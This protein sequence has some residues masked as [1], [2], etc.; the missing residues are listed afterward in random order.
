MTCGYQNSAGT[1]LD[2]LFYIS[3]GNAGPV[4]FQSSNGQDLGNRYSNLVLLGI[5]LAIKIRLGR[6]WAI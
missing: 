2:S 4:G 3:N 6:T 5:P 1:D